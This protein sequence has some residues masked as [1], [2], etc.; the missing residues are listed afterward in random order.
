VITSIALRSELGLRH[1]IEDAISVLRGETLSDSRRDFVIGDM[2]DLLHKIVRGQELV[3]STSLFMGS[4][5]RGAFEAFSLLDR[6]LPLGDSN[7]THNALRTSAARLSEIKEGKIVPTEGRRESAAFLAQ[8]LAS[9]ERQDSAGL[10]SE[11]EPH[12]IGN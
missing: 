1:L 8:I 2:Q 7:S 6:F 10:R 3:H 5:D 4:A 11:P 9:L 12:M